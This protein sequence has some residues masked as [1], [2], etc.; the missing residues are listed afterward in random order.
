M[1]RSTFRMILRQCA[2]AGLLVVLFAAWSLAPELPHSSEPLGTASPA[3]RATPRSLIHPFVQGS[4]IGIAAE[5][6]TQRN[7]V[8]FLNTETGLANKA[9]RAN[10]PLATTYPMGTWVNVDLS[11]CLPHPA[12]TKAVL[13][14]GVLI[15]T[16]RG[17][18]PVADYQA[19]LEISFRAPKTTYDY[20]KIGQSAT[21]QPAEGPRTSFACWVPVVKGVLQF[22]WKGVNV[23]TG[24]G[25]NQTRYGVNLSLGGY[26]Q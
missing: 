21:S 8:I 11:K 24:T 6:P 25:S 7:P 9:E 5:S 2:F 10:L 17:D 22:K 18:H 20:E 3:T 16:N 4:M 14:Q 12:A 19:N 23:G 1:Q 13:L 26:L 15:V